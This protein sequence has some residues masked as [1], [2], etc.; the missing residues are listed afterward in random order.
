MVDDGERGARAQLSRHE[1]AL[2]MRSIA[3]AKRSTISCE[4]VLGHLRVLISD[5]GKHRSER[6]PHAGARW[7]ASRQVGMAGFKGRFERSAERERAGRGSL[8][9]RE[10]ISVRGAHKRTGLPVGSPV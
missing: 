2:D 1:I 4:N 3:I 8:K 7:R 5:N 10:K 6:A 9:R